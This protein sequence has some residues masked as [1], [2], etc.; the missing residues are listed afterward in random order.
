MHSHKQDDIYIGM[1]KAIEAAIKSST[2]T[3]EELLANGPLCFPNNAAAGNGDTE[4]ITSPQVLLQDW[5]GTLD[6]LDNAEG[7][8][9]KGLSIVVDGKEKGGMKVNVL[10]RMVN[11]TLLEMGNQ[12]KIGITSDHKAMRADPSGVGQIPSN[13]PRF[14]AASHTHRQT[15]IVPLEESC[16]ELR[17]LPEGAKVVMGV[18]REMSLISMRVQELISFVHN[19]Y[20][21]QW[22]DNAAAFS[23]WRKTNWATL[24]F[25]NPAL[26]ITK[27]E[28][29]DQHSLAQLGPIVRCILGAAN[30]KAMPCGGYYAQNESAPEGRVTAKTVPLQESRRSP[31]EVQTSWDLLAV[32]YAQ[33]WSAA[34][35]A[36][37]QMETHNFKARKET[38]ITPDGLPKDRDAF[39]DFLIEHIDMRYGTRVL[40]NIAENKEVPVPLG[41]TSTQCF[42]LLD[43][44]MRSVRVLERPPASRPPVAQEYYG[45]LQK[46]HAFG[47][48]VVVATVELRP[49]L[50]GRDIYMNLSGLRTLIPSRFM[51]QQKA[52]WEIKENREMDPAKPIQLWIATD[53]IDN[54]RKAMSLGGNPTGK[55][56]DEQLALLTLKRSSL[57]FDAAEAPTPKRQCAPSSPCGEHVPVS[58]PNDDEF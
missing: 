18:L 37:G 33:R 40:A 31:V 15:T 29:V 56:N 47:G 4:M 21:V 35:E 26:G 8:S 22:K 52:D 6:E 53:G 20:A 10:G 5:Q 3:L 11:P 1:Q 42:D 19:W 50:K 43:Q 51:S 55:A 57:C 32:A 25:T 24:A 12:Q 28:E 46:D 38:E 41:K 45:F 39:Y 58:P 49:S 7:C 27:A 2:G 13:Y 34:C 44:E 16:K 14:A 23:A 36:R 30:I 48:G 17:Y 9:K 54:Q